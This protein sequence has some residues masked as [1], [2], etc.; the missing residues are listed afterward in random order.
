MNSK[1]EFCDY[2]SF[3]QQ[4]L[5]ETS[6]T[7]LIYPRRPIFTYHFMFVPKEH[8]PYFISF[9]DESLIDMKATM[10]LVVGK[11][12][13]SKEGF[14]GYNLVSNNGDKRVGQ[15]V[16]HY[17]CHMFLRRDDEEISPYT[18][19]NNRDLTDDSDGE[20]R[21]ADF[22]ILKKKLAE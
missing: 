10:K 14:I 6:R 8:A 16:P 17:H 18:L 3:S 7:Y 15:K 4:L 22:N 19:M 9:S 12:S 20:K 13:K 1:C 5:L 21:E 11:L 2:K